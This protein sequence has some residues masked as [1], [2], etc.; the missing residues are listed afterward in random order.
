MSLFVALSLTSLRRTIMSL[1]EE[2]RTLIGTGAE[3]IGR[4]D[5]FRSWASAQISIRQ[6]IAQGV[7]S[8]RCLSVWLVATARTYEGCRRAAAAGGRCG[9]AQLH[10]PG[11]R[12]PTTTEAALYRLGTPQRDAS[13]KISN[14]VLLLHGT[15]NTGKS[16]L[17]PTL[18][19][20]LF[21]PG[22]PLDAQRYY[23]VLPDGIGEG[24][25]TKPSAGMRASFPRYRSHNHTHRAVGLF[26]ACEFWR[27]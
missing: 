1:L 15:T 21:Q 27:Q 14:A 5:P 12:A 24:E 7:L 10:F 18:A 19:D 4:E 22:Q 11:R 25:S 13:G 20:Y 16:F 26:R 17:M 8:F 9:S 6:Q 2:Q 3:C 23:V